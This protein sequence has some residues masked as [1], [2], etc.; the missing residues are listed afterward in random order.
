MVYLIVWKQNY[1]KK[2][3]K[4]VFSNQKRFH[5]FASGKYGGKI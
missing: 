4:K 2:R 1:E 5:T 3:Y